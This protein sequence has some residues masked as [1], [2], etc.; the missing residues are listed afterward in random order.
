[1]SVVEI[2][3]PNCG[4]PSVK[5]NGNEYCCNNCGRYFQVVTQTKNETKQVGVVPKLKFGKVNFKIDQAKQVGN[6]VLGSTSLNYTPFQIFNYHAYKKV[7]RGSKP[8]IANEFGYVF[9]NPFTGTINT[10]LNQ[11]NKLPE[12]NDCKHGIYQEAMK[13]FFNAN[14]FEDKPPMDIGNTPNIL[15]LAKLQT[16]ALSSIAANLSVKKT[17]IQPTSIGKRSGDMGIR[18]IIMKFSKKDFVEFGSVVAFWLPIFNLSYK[19]PNS[20]KLFRR[21]ISAF[22][23]EI[24]SD[25]LRCS[26]TKTLGKAC[27]NFPD[28]VCSACGNLV[29]IEHERRCEKCG[30]IL[31]ENCGVSK[32]ILSKHYFCS[33]CG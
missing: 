18:A 7:I 23:G 19:H 1:M 24:L 10:Y 9:V 4:S 22:S 14:A 8:V 25:E 13:V 11:T 6:F 31:C 20:T 28:N 5:K 12:I 30:S 27:E 16:L 29:C 21:S 3:C 17:Y 2:R 26:K 33:K 32:G 15:P